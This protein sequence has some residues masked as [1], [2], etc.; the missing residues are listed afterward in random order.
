MT[1]DRTRKDSGFTL[2]ELL[3]A[4]TMTGLIVS[5][6]AMTIAVS[7]RNLPATS[8]RADSSVLIQGLTTF[9]PP[10][11]DST[12]PDRF[13]VDPLTG[14]GCGG[15]DPGINMLKLSWNETYRGVTT[16][17]VADY[18]WVDE[19][20]SAHIVRVFCQ[21]APS[22]GAAQTVSMTG[23][24]STTP[25]VV[26]A[27]NYL[28]V[29]GGEDDFVVITVETLA[30][31]SVEIKAATKN[32]DDELPYEP[33][34]TP[35]APPN[36]APYA[37]DWTVNVEPLV[38]RTFTLPAGDI[39]S[40]A[41]T[42]SLGALPAE[43]TVALAGLDFTVTSTALA[44]LDTTYSFDYTVTDPAGE[45]VTATISV[46]VVAVPYEPADPTYGEA[47]PCIVDSMTVNPN[48]V[49][50]ASNG[51]G[52]LKN[53]VVV[54]ISI[55]SGYCIGLHLEYATGAPDGEYIQNFGNS[56]PYSITLK[57]HPHGTELWAAGNHD[58]Y[59]KDGE[60]NVLAQA[61]LKV[62]A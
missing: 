2:P 57:G 15:T 14:S 18:R 51:S 48:P 49:K 42:I 21:G 38:P 16:N 54:A 28:Q 8:A 45:T 40:D 33:P 24:L 30:G 3:I 53:D 47:P 9:L 10:D 55:D 22:L 61:T 1:R 4:V 62:S 11:V 23:P 36:T 17:F 50:L 59:V 7:L 32:P 43:L 27:G 26:T 37:S 13:D 19:G 31:E 20:D 25:P 56:A 35:E 44:V 52:K 58:L 5:V 39:N 12:E 46:E 60:D 41:I 6:I 29:V 34:P